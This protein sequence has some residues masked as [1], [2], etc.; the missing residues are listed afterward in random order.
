MINLNLLRKAMDEIAARKGDFTLFALVMRVDAPDAWDLVVSARW[1]DGRKLNAT[2]EF[3]QLLAKSIGEESLRQ[4]SR[5]ATV[6]SDATIVKFIRANFP[7]ER[8]ENIFHTQSFDLD[9]LQVQ[10]AIIFRAKKVKGN[11]ARLLNPRLQPLA[12]RTRRG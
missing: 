9:G 11:S 10:E 6:D 7:V 2:S 4:F 12:Q 3:V 8:E 5:I 1:L